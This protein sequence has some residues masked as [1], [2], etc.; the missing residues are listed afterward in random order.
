[1]AKMPIDGD[2][3][4]YTE[5]GLLEK[6]WMTVDYFVDTLTLGLKDHLKNKVWGTGSNSL[7]HHPTDLAV[8]AAS[9]VEVAYNVIEN[10]G[11]AKCDLSES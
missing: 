10:F 3:P 5:D 4:T 8:H 6:G 9:Y 2:F 11:V 1:M 7:L